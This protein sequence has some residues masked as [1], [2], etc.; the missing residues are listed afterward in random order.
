MKFQSLACTV[1]KIWQASKTAMDG[2]TL[3]W[4]HSLTHAQAKR[5][6]P[7]QF[8]KVW[9]IKSA[10]EWGQLCSK[11]SFGEVYRRYIYGPKL[12]FTASLTSRRK[13]KFGP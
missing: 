3:A 8:F 1:H 13:K 11:F 12:R 5:N 10:L 7:H 2:R 9:G 4:T 6:M